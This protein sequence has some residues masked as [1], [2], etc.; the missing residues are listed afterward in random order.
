[1]PEA[2]KLPEER[3][4]MIGLEI[5]FQL[6][7]GKLF[8]SCPTYSDGTE[9]LRFTRRLVPTVSEL[10]RIDPA[11]EY[12]RGR[13]REFEYI[14]TDN[15]CLVEY[16]EEPPHDVNMLALETALIV[17]RA[18]NCKILDRISFM[19]KVVVDGSNTSGFQRTA[20]VGL[21]GHIETSRG[22]VRIS[23]VSMEE[24]SAR[25]ID[26]EKHEAGKVVYSLDR[27]G[28]PL[29]EIATEP[30]IQDG[31]HAVEVAKKIG[32][33]VMATGNA[34][35]EVDSIR[36]DVNMSM[37][38]GRVEIKGVQKLSLIKETL[39]YEVQRQR[40]LRKISEIISDRGGFSVS[41]FD[42]TDV[43]D[44]FRKT[45]SGVLSRGLSAENSIYATIAPNLEGTLKKDTLR[46][47]KELS[48]VAKAYGLGG[49]MHSDELP[50]FGITSEELSIVY[51]KLGGKGK[52]ALIMVLCRE[53]MISRVSTAL[54]DRIHKIIS[55]GLSE[56]RGPLDDGTTKY[57][58]PLPG[59]ERMYPETDLPIA[60]VSPEMKGRV[61]NRIPKSGDENRKML[62]SKYGISDQEA[63]I[64]VSGFLVA[65]FEKYVEKLNEP[66]TV[67]RIM[68]QTVPEV[69]KK[70]QAKIRKDQ[71]LSLFEVAS[72]SKW[73]RA[74]LEKALELM[75]S[76][77]LE[78]SGVS[79]REELVPLSDDELRALLERLKAKFGENLTNKNVIAKLKSETN[80]I[81]EPSRVMKLFQTI[82]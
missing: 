28:T 58:R 15:S 80:R 23:S 69:E 35:R 39:N 11:A 43:S 53:D 51:D 22:T 40:S 41:K 70:Y 74:S 14:A 27:L 68:L 56:T 25:K 2:S 63:H 81:I 47:G 67:S 42:F 75:A 37:G 54:A 16:D 8:C 32:Y 44:V 4:L 5:H 49:I 3:K 7:T 6:D 72:S 34:R 57:L 66:K 29:I 59:S 18:L 21:D 82:E 64:M 52:G 26:N 12:E 33:Y 10:G 17:S 36:Q 71:L 61:E 55:M 50:A 77:K 79:G 73:A 13:K 60:V 30:D 31:D 9:M 1:M 62:V 48:D 46:L 65:D 76:E 45:G 20:L 19:R 78:V 24:D 38:F